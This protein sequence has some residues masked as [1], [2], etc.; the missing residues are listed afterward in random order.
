MSRIGDSRAV[1][2][3]RV[4]YLYTV[5]LDSYDRVVGGA[6]ISEERPDFLW[7]QERADFRGYYGNIESLYE[8]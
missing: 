2:S 6:W 4:A 8:R 1:A 3:E 7:V 5:E